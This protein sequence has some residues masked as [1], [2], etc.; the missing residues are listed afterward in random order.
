M[1]PYGLARSAMFPV[2]G[3]AEASLAATFP[4]PGTGYATVTVRRDALSVGEP[5]EAPRSAMISRNG[6]GGW[7]TGSRLSVPRCG[8][9]KRHPVPATVGRV[10]IR[11]DNV[12]RGYYRDPQRPS[13]ISEA[14]GSIPA[15]LAS[16]RRRPCDLTGR[17]KEILFVSGQTV[18]PQDLEA[19]IDRNAGIELG[20]V[21]VCGVRPQC[22]ERRSVGLRA[23]PRRAQGFLDTIKAVRKSVNEQI[24]VVVNHVI[25]VRR[26]P[27]TTSGKIQRYLLADA[28]RRGNSTTFWPRCTS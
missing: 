11:G 22:G 15:I 21:A 14:A 3:L 8:D 27:K 9:T 2:Y 13:V 26:I 24:G 19:V 20:K 18:Y 4:P 1:A 5:V 28:Y 25:P 12:T 7:A 10:L 16:Y 17:I 6:H 23:L